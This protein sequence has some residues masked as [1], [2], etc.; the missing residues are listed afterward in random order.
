MRRLLLTLLLGATPAWAKPYEPKIDKIEVPPATV[1]PS[2]APPQD[3]PNRPLSA[4]E[5]ARIALRYQANIA[6]AKYQIT[7]AQGRTEQSRSGLRPQLTV[8][9]SYTDII[10]AANSAANN[11]ALLGNTLIAGAAGSSN[12]ISSATENSTSLTAN[13]KQLVFDFHHTRDLVQQAKELENVATANYT[14]TQLDTVLNVKQAF[15]TY[16]QNVRLIAV[17]EG[18]VDNQR[19]HLRQAQSRFRAGL[20]LPS[21]VVRAQT[22]VANAV[23][24]LQQARSDA[25]VARINLVLQMGLDPRIP[26]LVNDKEEPEISADDP[27]KLFDEALAKRPEV[28]SALANLRSTKHG[29][30]AASSISA[31]TVSINFSYSGRILEGIPQTNALNLALSINWTAYDG[32]L[33]DGKVTEAQGNLGAAKAQLETTIQTVISD[34]AQDYYKLKTAEQKLKTVQI[35]EIN[36]VESVRLADGRYKVGLGILLDV[37][38]AQAALRTAQTNVINAVTQINVAR[39]TLLRAI[40]KPLE[41]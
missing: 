27:Q 19:E 25:D 5:A 39:A 35:E 26:I 38:D 21:D 1:V 36:A 24:N 3:F 18:N 13:L 10:M 7:A 20:G 12:S 15:Y 14:K 40:G 29:L 2:V 6:S 23:Q 30:S 16:I 4:D 22:A 37:L 9:A 41:T 32:G 8:G 28:A 17:Q 34:V 31:P 33:Q 11:A